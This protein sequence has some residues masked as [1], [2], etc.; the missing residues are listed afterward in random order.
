M[1]DLAH[2]QLQQ[3][4]TQLGLQSPYAWQVQA[5][6][7]L[8]AGRIPSQIKV[9]TSAGKTMVM[10]LF[11][12]ALA[13]QAASGQVR[14]PR[15]LVVAVNRR[16]L[17]D[18]A[19]R[20]AERL[21]GLLHSDALPE[22]R[23]ALASLSATGTP[24]EVSTLRGEFA[25]NGR[26]SLDP[27]T[28]AIVLATPDMLGSRLLFRGYG[29]GRSRSATHAGLLG[30]DTLVVH[31]EA[32]LAPAFSALLR[33]IES[34]AA[35]GASAIGRPALQVIEMTATLATDAPRP[36]LVCDVS[37][38]AALAA[39]MQAVKRLSVVQV[40]GNEGKPAAQ[41]LGE[42]LRRALALRGD[43]Q[44]VAMFV[45]SPD[46]A[47]KVAAGLVKG[48]VDAA[49]IVT[50]TGTMRGHERAAIT[51][52]AA[53][54]RFAA[55]E[56]RSHD[57]SAYFVATAA[58][59]IGL[60]IDADIGLFDLTTLDRFIQR[61]GRINRRG[62][63]AGQIRLL[64][65]GGDEVNEALRERAVKAL[66]LLGSLPVQGEQV[67]ASPLALTA[68]AHHADYRLAIEPAPCERRL[69]PAIVDM[70][71]M[72]SLT[73]DEIGAP[74]P[75]VFIHGLVDEDTEVRLAWR[76]LPDLRADWADW[77]D[78]WPVSR[79]ETAK[80]PIGAARNL[81]DK[82]LQQQPR[83]GTGPVAALL[84]AQGMPVAGGVLLA[85]ERHWRWLNRL[86][87]GAIVLLRPDLGG[88]ASGLPGVEHVAPVDD[89]S[90]GHVDA[91]GLQRDSSGLLQVH[92]QRS[93]VHTVW[94]ASHDNPGS[95]SD[96]ADE[97]TVAS[98][99]A[100]AATLDELLASVAPGLEVVFHDGPTSVPAE[101]WS[102]SVR[103]WLARRELLSADSGD[104]ASLSRCDRLLTEHLDLAGR[105][106]RALVAHLPLSGSLDK[107]VVRAACEHDRGKA[108]RI[109]QS[110]IG[111]RGAT[112]DTALAKSASSRFDHRINDGYRHELGSVVDRGAQ[113]SIVERHLV[114]SHHG[115]ARP[116]FRPQAL[117]K[118]GCAAAAGP[119]ATGFAQLTDAI[120]PWALAYLEAVLKSADVL[121]ELQADQLAAEPALAVPDQRAVLA[122]PQE[123]AD[124]W[125]MPVDVRNFGEYLACLGLAALLTRSARP[126]SIG[127]EPGT[128]CLRGVGASDVGQA[129]ALLDDAT[130]ALDEAATP[131]A[132]RDDAYP[133]LR[134]TL[135][136]RSNLALNHWLAADFQDKS[137]WKLG[138]GQTRALNTLQAL[139][140]SCR[141]LRAL[142]GFSVDTLFSQGGGLVGAEASKLRFDAA[143]NWSA[144]DAGFSL[145]EDD[146]FKSVRPWVEVLSALGL[147]HC[148]VPP[149]DTR[150]RYHL[151]TGYLPHRLALAAVKGLLPQCGPA[152]VPTVLPNGK[153][154]DV[155]SSTSMTHER[156]DPWTAPHMLVI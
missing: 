130:V 94:T 43:N 13:R 82:L 114:A 52:L 29:V 69:E 115:W 110:A 66:A 11:V 80:L 126:F 54:R 152:Y 116:G 16:A 89:V 127:W 105:A 90:T 27:S 78:A 68:L 45:S 32:H 19:S 140:A 63:G 74:P 112:A 119:V 156:K 59:E 7:A 129:L 100:P 142:P 33:Q 53:Y 136:D 92:C 18:D 37:A 139:L 97:D 87:G 4:L 154:K 133:P 28:P 91:N 96:D 3:M 22:L 148:F 31:D 76:H 62:L 79:H 121:A 73:L 134:L 85:G 30:V 20:L 113:L 104:L 39:R 34:L 101:G 77:L 149:G 84:D 144:R 118:P 60:D 44:A 106:A 128:F 108:W 75:D 117:A 67:D 17:V 46:Q 8:C 5:Y 58:G 23:A 48:G 47:A 26:W 14:L 21:H 35:A 51:S 55:D 50:L 120:G 153:M 125:R 124:I 81:L 141:A 111:R 155:F 2:P 70:L 151:W 98:A 12:A 107:A 40:A 38:D 71:A 122:L 138:A 95:A 64:H 49:R 65:A 88:L 143:T 1:N 41:L 10:A 123:S 132:A 72:T 147:Q 56:T 86:R 6:E 145:N 99:I 9:P 36:P 42:L 61:A 25:D 146:R 135:A 102:G 15:R 131:P 57:G 93:D 150:P 24:L 137:G 109:W 103:Y 83:D